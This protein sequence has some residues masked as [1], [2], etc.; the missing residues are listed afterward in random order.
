VVDPRQIA[1]LL[2]DDIDLSNPSDIWVM[3]DCPS[4]D[5]Q[6][7]PTHGICINDQCSLYDA[8]WDRTIASLR[9]IDTS[10]RIKEI[11]GTLESTHDLTLNELGRFFEGIEE[12][13]NHRWVDQSGFYSI[14]A[15]L[16]YAADLEQGGTF[17]FWYGDKDVPDEM[18]V[19]AIV[20]KGWI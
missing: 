3:K 11:D 15:S 1:A 7:S 2:E 8:E 12:G 10:K 20:A 5:L 6:A 9:R 18:L 13:M 4:C 17:I 16:E 14:N 19:F